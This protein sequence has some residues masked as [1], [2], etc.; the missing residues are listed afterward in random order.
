ME[1]CKISIVIPAYIKD[2]SQII[3]LENA[4]FCYSKMMN[5]YQ[6]AHI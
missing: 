3:F 1:N 4:L 5:N 2:S 6:K